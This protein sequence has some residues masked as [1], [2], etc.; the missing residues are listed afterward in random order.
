M[1]QMTEQSAFDPRLQI[2]NY[3]P[4]TQRITFGGLDQHHMGP[5]IRQ[6]FAAVAAGDSPK[7]VD[8]PQ[9]A[10]HPNVLAQPKALSRT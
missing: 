5:G 7:C 2:S 8:N 1:M 4:R 3:V 10:D 6:Q 9:A